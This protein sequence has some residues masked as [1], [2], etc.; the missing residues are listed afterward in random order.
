MTKE[1]NNCPEKHKG[2]RLK[3]T[4][5][6]DALFKKVSEERS[7]TKQGPKIN[8]KLAKFTK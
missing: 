4:T 2:K 8:K 5:S 1:M 3:E 7:G 6:N